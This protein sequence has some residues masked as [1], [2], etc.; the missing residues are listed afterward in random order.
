MRVINTSTSNPDEFSKFDNDQ[1]YNGLACLITR[2][3]WDAMSPELGSN[4]HPEFRA[5]YEFSKALQG[6]VLEMNARGV[7]IASAKKAQVIDEF[8]DQLDHLERNLER[9]VLEG[10]GMPGF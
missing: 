5:T 10:V 1:I 6:P 8:H 2:Q 9:I 7:R 3:V 4:K